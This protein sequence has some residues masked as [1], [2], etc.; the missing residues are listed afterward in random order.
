MERGGEKVEVENL[1][2]VEE[3]NQ[4]SNLIE[5]PLQV[6]RLPQLDLWHGVHFQPAEF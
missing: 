5:L 2:H 1:C 6:A 3:E 4:C